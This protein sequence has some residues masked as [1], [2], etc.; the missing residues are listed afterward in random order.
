MSCNA[1]TMHSNELVARTPLY[2]EKYF[3]DATTPF[4]EVYQM[5]AWLQTA[6]AA[7]DETSVVCLATENKAILAAALLAGLGNG[8]SL[9]MP[10][11]LAPKKLARMQQTTGFTT[12]I[13]EQADILPSGT[14]LLQPKTD[15]A[16]K[17]CFNAAS[18]RELL[19]LF[20]GG[21]TGTPQ[22]WS[23]TGENLF[24]EARYL[25]DYLAISPKDHITATVSPCHIYGL[26]FSVLIPLV[27]SATV[28]TNTPSFPAEIAETVQEEKSTI[29]A[30][31]PAHYRVLRQQVT[32]RGSLRFSVSSAGMLDPGDNARF[33][34]HNKIPV[35]EVYGSTETGGIAARNRAAG[36][37]AFAPFAT[38]DWKISKNRLLVRSPYI[39]P[40]TP[41]D[42]DGFFVTGDR[43]EA[44]A[45]HS[46]LLQGRVDGI[47]KVGGKRVDLEEIREVLKKQP[48]VAD[49]F[50]LTLPDSGGRENQICALVQ[51]NKV[52][53]EQLLTTLQSQLSPYALPRIFRCIDTIPMTSAGKYDL[54]AIRRLLAP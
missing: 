2:P 52:H 7:L 24:G 12:A 53:K 4:A 45:N 34:E 39:S 11:G 26:L 13:G 10:N 37:T 38:V 14:K 35:I 22:V 47:T 42:K 51:T 43:A 40:Q 33:C 6:F 20:T 25:T 3:T 21:S 46:F 31:V 8:P 50:V 27:S 32:S 29:L 18:N 49:C 54:A 44:G 9:L 36:E 1:N 16:N 23:K 5:A 19:R 15:T 28:S 17:L 41:R 30:A 48:G